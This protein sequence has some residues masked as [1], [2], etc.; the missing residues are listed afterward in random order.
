MAKANRCL[1]S[2]KEHWPRGGDVEG[3]QGVTQPHLF[4]YCV[5]AKD[6]ETVGGARRQEVGQA[7]ASEEGSV[8]QIKENR[9]GTGRRNNGDEAAEIRNHSAGK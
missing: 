9:L 2:E 5:P 1:F 8:G 3:E 7:L 6:F 4:F